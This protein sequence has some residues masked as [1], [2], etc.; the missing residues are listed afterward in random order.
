[1]RRL[2]PGASR[3]TGPAGRNVPRFPGTS[4][5]PSL[6]ANDPQPFCTGL[7]QPRVSLR[8]RKVVL[9][10]GDRLARAKAPPR[11]PIDRM[12]PLRGCEIVV[13]PASS[14]LTPKSAAGRRTLGLDPALRDVLA[15]R[16]A[17]GIGPYVFGR[18]GR[19]RP[20]SS[21]IVA[22]RARKAWK[23]A[24]VPPLACDRAAGRPATVGDLTLQEVRHT[25][26]SL[27]LSEGVTLFEVSRRI[28]HSSIA[29]TADRY[30]HLIPDRD[31]AA[32]AAVGALI[33][34]A[35]AEAPIE[36]S[37]QAPSRGI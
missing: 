22:R 15:D 32:S 36:D 7:T 37:S 26:A 35:R 3:A 25:F 19:A 4:I 29:I 27:A 24:E 31:D 17:A 5:L 6:E 11:P 8:F 14:G 1:M 12:T 13:L 33:A 9:P 10:T 34:H 30:G 21:G 28:G 2:H 20:F 18:D 23:A 16:K